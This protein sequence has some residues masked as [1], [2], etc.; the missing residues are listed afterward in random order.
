MTVGVGRRIADISLDRRA[1]DV[2]LCVCSG[3]LVPYVSN[4]ARGACLPETS[5]RVRLEWRS[6]RKDGD[7]PNMRT[8]L[9]L[10]SRDE[11]I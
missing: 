8:I 7:R 6:N 5:C 10:V 4:E 11:V 9:D 2:V 1:A 3:A